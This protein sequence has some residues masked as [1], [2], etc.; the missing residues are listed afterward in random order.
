MS[1]HTRYSGYGKWWWYTPKHKWLEIHGPHTPAAMP[2][3]PACYALVLDGE[4]VYV[5]QTLNLQNRFYS[6]QIKHD[7]KG[8]WL[9][10]WGVLPGDLRLKVKF[11]Q[12]FGDWCMREA[13]LIDRLQPRF[14]KR[15]I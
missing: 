8:N 4:V 7:R 9:T 5:G 2:Q 6:H 12:R 3:V 15:L 13:R 10:K 14:N 1:F 11:G